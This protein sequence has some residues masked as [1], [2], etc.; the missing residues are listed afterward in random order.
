MSLSR[1]SYLFIADQRSKRWQLYHQELRKFWAEKNIPFDYEMVQWLELIRANGQI[2]LSDIRPGT[3]L[4]IES[5]A[6]DF[7]VTREFL[8][9]GAR[10]TLSDSTQYENVVYEK[11]K[12]IEPA[13][14]FAG[15]KSVLMGF[16][17][18]LDQHENIVVPTSPSAIAEMFDKNATVGRLQKAGIRC[19]CTFSFEGNAI[20]LLAEIRKREFFTAYVKLSHGSSASGIAVVDMRTDTPSAVTSLMRLNGEFF[21]TRKLQK[22][23]GQLLHETLTFILNN[24]VC[25]QEG[26]PM[27]QVHGQNF[28]VRVIVIRG[29]PRFKIFRLSK[30][31]MT[32]LHLGGRRGVTD[33]CIKL[34]PKRQWLDAMDACVEAANLYDAAMVGVDVVFDRSLSQHFILELNGFGDFFPNWENADGKSVHTVQLE[35]E[36]EEYWKK[37]IGMK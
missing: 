24:G 3:L 21:N 9:A 2:D 25:V 18:S 10:S 7:E 36:Y 12:L 20:D 22:V 34:I 16:E 14:M 13:I 37:E 26:I 8:K 17:S 6:R 31:P 27:G 19:P 35:S 23:E 29:E 30:H 15:L 5:P 32:N 1:P 11:G 33:D 28:D 4:R